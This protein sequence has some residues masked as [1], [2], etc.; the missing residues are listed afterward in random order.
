MTLSGLGECGLDELLVGGGVPGLQLVRLLR[1]VGQHLVRGAA[2]VRRH[3]EAGVDAALEAGDA[4]HEELVEVRGED[5]EEV[6]ALE[7]R[8]PRVLGE[9]EHALVE[10]EPAELAVEVALGEQLGRAVDVERFEVVVEVAGGAVFV[11]GALR[12]HPHI[13]PPGCDAG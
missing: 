6:R 5:R 9:L 13:M 4:H 10:R 8:Q 11:E 12:G 7:D 2:D 1:D 3:G